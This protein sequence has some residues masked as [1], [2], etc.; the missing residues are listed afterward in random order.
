LK[1]DEGRVTA[2]V[3]TLEPGP[4]S[5]SD[6]RFSRGVDAPDIFCGGDAT[7]YGKWVMDDGSVMRVKWRGQSSDGAV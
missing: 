3:V 6:M 2:G 1:G 5:R 4:M 7:E